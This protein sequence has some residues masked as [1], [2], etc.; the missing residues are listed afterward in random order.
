MGLKIQGKIFSWCVTSILKETKQ[1]LVIDFDSPEIDSNIVL[2]KAEAESLSADVNKKKAELRSHTKLPFHR[3]LQLEFCTE[4][5]VKMCVCKSRRS[6]IAQLK[7][8]C[9]P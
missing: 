7:S 1:E 8:G 5:D 2:K 4:N 3:L 6:F 9:C